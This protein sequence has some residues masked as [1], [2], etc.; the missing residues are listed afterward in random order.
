MINDKHIF[1]NYGQ[2]GSE[3]CLAYGCAYV[4]CMSLARAIESSKSNEVAVLGSGINSLI[5]A[6]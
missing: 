6:I 5:T 3:I 4:C 1:H 2:G